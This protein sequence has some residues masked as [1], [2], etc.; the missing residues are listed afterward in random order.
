MKIT[1]RWKYVCDVANSVGLAMS[2]QPVSTAGRECAQRSAALATGSSSSLSVATRRAR[3]SRQALT[4]TTGASSSAFPGLLSSA[5]ARRG[6]LTVCGCGWRCAAAW[7]DARQ[8]HRWTATCGRKVCD[9]SVMRR[10]SAEAHKSVGPADVAPPLPAARRSP[11]LRASLE[12]SPCPH[13][14]A[15]AWLRRTFSAGHR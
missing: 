4:S 3:K 15:G 8:A 6:L 1:A 5:E 2:T 11:R 7:R 9:S 13:C 14:Q 12:S 10:V